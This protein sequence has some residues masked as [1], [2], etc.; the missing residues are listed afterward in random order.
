MSI[1]TYRSRRA[2]TV[3]VAPLLLL[4]LPLLPL[5]TRAAWGQEIEWRVV[6][7]GGGEMSGA[8]G[9]L[10]G[11]LSQPAVGSPEGTLVGIGEGFW[12][13]VPSGTGAAENAVENAAGNAVAGE[14]GGAAVTGRVVPIGEEAREE[15]SVSRTFAEVH[16]EPASTREERPATTAELTL[17]PNPLDASALLIWSVPR[18]GHV[19]IELFD[20]AGGLVELLFNGVVAAGRMR[21]VLD[22]RRYPS[23][24]YFLRLVTEDEHVAHTVRVVR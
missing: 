20:A 2:G 14:S 4:L 17:T 10:E 21:M 22:G 7:G 8:V 18:D 6:A 16:T 9:M 11:T 19:R 23:G 15:R 1:L 24:T 13:G 3:G 5:A 12:Y